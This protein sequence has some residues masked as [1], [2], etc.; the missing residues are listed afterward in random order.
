MVHRVTKFFYS[1]SAVV[2][3]FSY[4]K[5]RGIPAAI[6]YIPGRDKPFSVWVEGH[7]AER[8]EDF[9]GEIVDSCD[10]FESYIEE[11]V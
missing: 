5:E 4:F 8:D 7:D 11:V 6:V 1:K 2:D 9:T 10:M 3:W